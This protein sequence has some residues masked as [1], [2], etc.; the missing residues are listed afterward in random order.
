MDSSTSSSDW[1]GGNRSEEINLETATLS[2]EL[3]LLR[4]QKKSIESQLD[5]LSSNPEKYGNKKQVRELREEL[6]EKLQKMKKK[7][8]KLKQQLN[9]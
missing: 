2:N 7:I 8:K 5:D 9:E 3:L 4:N 1:G 6:E